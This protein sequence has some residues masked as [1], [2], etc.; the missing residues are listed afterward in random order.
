[1]IKLD[2]NEN[3]Y[4]APDEVYDAMKEADLHRYPDPAQGTFN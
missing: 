3:I 2:A 4:G 1:M